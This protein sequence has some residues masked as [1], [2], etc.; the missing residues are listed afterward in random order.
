MTI[1]LGHDMNIHDD[2]V[3]LDSPER[4]ALTELIKTQCAH[5]RPK[6]PPFQP[7]QFDDPGDDYDAASTT[8]QAKYS[9]RCELC[10]GL[11]H[12]GDWISRTSDGD[13]ICCDCL[14]D[15]S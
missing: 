3:P 2:T 7:A 11:F 5:C 15:A 13:Y 14:Q 6:P 1:D 4:C 9:G 8:F 12:V 10:D